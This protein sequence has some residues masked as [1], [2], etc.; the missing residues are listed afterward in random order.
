M[1]ACTMVPD[2]LKF[3]DNVRQEAL[4]QVRRLRHHPSLALWCGNN[5]VERAW[6]SWG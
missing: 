5:E 1:F 3:H 6:A 2:D 4:E